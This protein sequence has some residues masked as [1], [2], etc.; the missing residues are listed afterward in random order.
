VNIN[1]MKAFKIPWFTSEGARLEFRGEI[2]NVFNR[3]NLLRPVSDLSSSLF[4]RSIDQSL[5][6]QENLGLRIQ[7]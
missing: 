5:P 3:V 4:G 7:F 2:F 1:L 6:R